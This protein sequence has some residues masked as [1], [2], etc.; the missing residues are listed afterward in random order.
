[1]DNRVLSPQATD[2]TLHG[3]TLVHK[4]QA[5]YWVLTDILQLQ[6][7]AAVS[8]PTLWSKAAEYEV[9]YVSQTHKEPYD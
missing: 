9:F 3:T 7:K 8:D 4:Q 2:I 5:Y 6:V 1:M